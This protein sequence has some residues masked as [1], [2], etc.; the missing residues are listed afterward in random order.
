MTTPNNTPNTPILLHTDGALAKALGC[1]VITV[2]TWRKKR[3][4]PYI[5]TGHRSISYN[6]P[7]VLAALESHETPAA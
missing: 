6:L 7:K 3:L 2:R 4:I 5:Q 1:S